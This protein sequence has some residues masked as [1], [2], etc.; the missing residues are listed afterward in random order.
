MDACRCDPRRPDG[1]GSR[2]EQWPSLGD[3]YKNGE[4]VLVNWNDPKLAAVYLDYFDR[5]QRQAKPY[6][7]QS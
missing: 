6:E 3:H 5:N 1:D 7:L 2:V 4:N